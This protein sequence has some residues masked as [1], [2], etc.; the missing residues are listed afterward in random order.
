MRKEF[1]RTLT[2]LM[3][4]DPQVYL[5][6]PDFSPP[7]DNNSVLAERT[8]KTSLTEQATVGIAAGMA[9]Q[10]LKPYVIGIT[11]FILERAFEQIKLDIV[12]QGANV[13]LVG[14]WDYPTAGPTHFTSDVPGLCKALGIRLSQPRDSEQTRQMLYDR[15]SKQEATFFY[16]TKDRGKG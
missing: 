12:Q 5:L 1:Y 15:H 6:S 9:L 10:G 7:Q 13:T 2:E 11:P 16:L 3:I 14:Y 4:K 8:I